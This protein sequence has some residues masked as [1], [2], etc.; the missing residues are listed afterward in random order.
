MSSDILV[1]LHI[2]E[3]IRLHGVPISIVSDRDQ[4][5]TS[6]F[7]KSLQKALGTRLNLSTAFH[8]QTDG[9]SERVI[10]ILE[11]ML[12]ACVIDFNRNWEKSIP[13][14]EFA[15]NNS[16]QTSIQMAPFEALYG[17]RC[18]TPTCW[19]E[20]G[21]NKV[22]G[23][24]MILNTEKQVKIIHDRLKQAFDRQK[25]YAD[26]KRRDIR[27]EVGNKVFLKVSPWKKVLR[28]DKKGKLS[29]RYIGPF[30]VLE[31]VG[32][33]AY[34]LALP[35]E[36]DK[37]NNVFHVSMLRRYRSDPS[38]VLEPEEVE[39][40]PDLSYEEEPVQILDREVKRLRNKNVSL[41][42]VL[43][44]NHKVEEATW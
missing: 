28:F 11:D 29:P 22:L 15:Y 36:F 18:R 4:K 2:R 34:R 23:P 35:P 17:R 12:R 20:L 32:H 8:L 24:Q 37:I 5:F 31:K 33:V 39:L 43:W 9:Q 26:T 38:H 30:E 14:V 40:N 21:E 41:V 13:S 42:K 44:R 6:R 3:V 27:Y 1:E 10:Q 25:A 16:Y 7:W 19:S